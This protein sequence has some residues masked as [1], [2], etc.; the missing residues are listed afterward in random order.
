VTTPGML[1]CDATSWPSGSIT[2]VQQNYYRAGN[3]K[4]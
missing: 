1:G 2:S 3:T 4:K